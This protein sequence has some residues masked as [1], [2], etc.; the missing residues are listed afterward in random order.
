MQKISLSSGCVAL[1]DDAYYGFLSQWKWSAALFRGRWYAFRNEKTGPGKRR[2]LLMHR[3]LCSAK[4]IDHKD[5]DGLNNQRKNLRSVTHAF[6]IFNQ[7]RKSSKV[8]G[9][10]NRSDCNRWQAEIT[11]QN[12]LRYLGLFVTFEAAL[13]ARHRAENERLKNES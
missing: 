5:G 12:K 1:V 8:R 9:V 11:I 7:K 2:V 4:E 13:E 6:N 10:R 3:V